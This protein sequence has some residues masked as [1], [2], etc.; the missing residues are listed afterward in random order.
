MGN[1]NYTARNFTVEML[2]KSEIKF[3][4]PVS[5]IYVP[6][7]DHGLQQLKSMFT[8]SEN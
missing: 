2:L 4:F 1:N 6:L 5:C 7:D 3:Q 8:F